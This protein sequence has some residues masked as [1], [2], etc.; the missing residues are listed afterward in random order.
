MRT[1]VA[2]P[3]LAAP[4]VIAEAEHERFRRCGYHNRLISL[5]GQNLGGNLALPRAPRP[6][7]RQPAKGRIRVSTIFVKEIAS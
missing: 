1:I 5:T 6:A 7:E 4:L 3:G 2:R